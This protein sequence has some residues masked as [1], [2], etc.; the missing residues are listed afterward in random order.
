MAKQQADRVRRAIQEEIFWNSASPVARVARQFGITKQ[1]VQF[2]VRALQDENVLVG[3]GERRNRRYRLKPILEKQQS[4]LLGTGVSEDKV[5]SAFVSPLLDDLAGPDITICEYGL[6]EMVNNVIDHSKAVQ[7]TVGV[8]LTQASVTLT[9]TDDGVGIFQKIASALG[10]ADPRL[11]LIELSKGKFT[12]D[13]A[14][15]TGEGIFFSSRSFDRFAIRSANLLFYHSTR[16]DDWLVDTKDKSFTGTRF[17]MGLITPTSRDHSEVFKKFSSGPDDY[18]F[19]KTHVPL[20]LATFGDESLV[21]RSSAKRALAR[22]QGF[23]E[24]LLDFRSVN[25][26]GQAFAD[27]MFR[28]FANAHPNVKLIYINANE[29]VTGMIRRAEA[30]RDAGQPGLSD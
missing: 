30:N 14:R 11:A 24:V 12:T 18:R 3:T 26:V 23:E 17:S 29:Q 9:V 8:T 25:S 22:V 28:V 16:T 10:L 21:S 1:A 15:H 20:D 19:S 5:W 4:Y 27:E 6:T 13:P 2:H 7:L